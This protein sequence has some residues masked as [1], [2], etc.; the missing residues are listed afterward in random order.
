MR[1][2]LLTRK[3]IT[4][5]TTSPGEYCRCGSSTLIVNSPKLR[6]LE[7]NGEVMREI[8]RRPDEGVELVDGRRSPAD[9][10]LL[11]AAFGGGQPG[12]VLRKLQRHTRRDYVVR[13]PTTSWFVAAKHWSQVRAS[14][15]GRATKILPPVE[16][17]LLNMISVA[18]AWYGRVLRSR[19]Y[20]RRMR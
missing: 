13:S 17:L 1:V 2:G 15:R 19:H 16:L 5:E 7:A 3:S 10:M 20:I 12:R 4:P 11:H 18:Q 9:G 8:K 6:D 14:L